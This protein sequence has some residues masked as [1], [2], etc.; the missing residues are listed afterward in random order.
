MTGLAHRATE[1]KVPGPAE[2]LEGGF[3]EDPQGIQR[4][5]G[6]SVSIP[7]ALS[8]L[9]VAFPTGRCESIIKVAG[10]TAALFGG[11]VH[12]SH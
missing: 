7:L 3:R 4:T 5:G 1:V 11:F 12:D 6:A 10:Q 9:K 2:T 8:T